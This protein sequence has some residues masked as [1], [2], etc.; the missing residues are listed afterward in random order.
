MI[1]TSLAHSLNIPKWARLIQTL[2]RCAMKTLK[3]NRERKNR[4]FLIILGILL[5]SLS[6]C[7]KE[8]VIIDGVPGR[9]YL[10]FIWTEH[11]PEYLDPGTFAIPN[12]FYW[13]EYYRIQAGY[14]TMYYDGAFYD[15]GS[16]VEYAWELDYEIFVNPGERGSPNYIGRDGADNYFTLECNPYGPWMYQDFKSAKLDE[17]VTIKE[18]SAEKIVIEKKKSDFT[19]RV[20]YKK[21]EKRKR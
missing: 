9:A 18:S 2:K 3:I 16:L 14:Y 10:A 5:L 21:V 15:R 8:V 17:G 1:N 11:E 20:T 6:A 4:S 19:L 13:D 12:V 7:Y